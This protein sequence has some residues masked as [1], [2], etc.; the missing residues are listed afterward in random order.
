[1]EVEVKDTTF[2]DIMD[3][4]NFDGFGDE[5]D[6]FDENPDEDPFSPKKTCEQCDGT[7]EAIYDDY[8]GNEIRYKCPRCRGTGAI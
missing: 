2:D 4:D 1:M 6:Y 8:E 5:F 7:G 3:L